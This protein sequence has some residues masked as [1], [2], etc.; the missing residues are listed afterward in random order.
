MQKIRHE[1][2]PAE[3]ADAYYFNAI[4]HMNRAE[5]RTTRGRLV[6]AE[7]RVKALEIELAAMRR[8][9]SREEGDGE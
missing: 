8:Q 7:A 1:M 6:V 9:A 4:G 5:R 3:E 2:T